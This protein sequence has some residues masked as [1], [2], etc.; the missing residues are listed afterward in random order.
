M[1]S[2]ESNFSLRSNY[3]TLDQTGPDWHPMNVSRQDIQI[4]ALTPPNSYDALVHNVPST[5]DGYFKIYD[6]Y[7]N[8][9]STSEGGYQFVNRTCSGQLKK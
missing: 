6:A 1:S 9:F 2:S 8:I 3:K 5:G 7:N 4:V